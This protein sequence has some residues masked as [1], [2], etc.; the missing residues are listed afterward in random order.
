MATHYDPSI[1]QQFADRLYQ[2]ADQIVLAYSLLGFALGALAGAILGAI[3][4]IGPAAPGLLCGGFLCLVFAL[5]GR[6]RSF[7]LRLQ[8]QTT[9]CQAQIEFNTRGARQ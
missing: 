9:L 3:T 4:P 1:I 8:A 2:Q 7:T 6:A 5:A